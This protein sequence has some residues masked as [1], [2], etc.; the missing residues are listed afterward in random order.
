M[1]VLIHAVCFAEDLEL[2]FARSSGPGGQNVNKVN[3]KADIRI[4]I[5]SATWIPA[6]VR[7]RLEAMQ[8]NKVNNDGELVVAS[9]RFRTQSE[10]T[11][12][13]IRKM[14]AYIDEACR[15]PK[16]PSAEKKK[17]VAGLAKKANEIRIDYKKKQGDKKSSRSSVKDW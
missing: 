3:T 9:D 5:K 15:I 7:A 12:D 17:R 1:G 14:Q 4:K 13:A 10:N 16:E 8:K 2:R 11:D 6:W